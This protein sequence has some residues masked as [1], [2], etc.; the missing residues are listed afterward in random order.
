MNPI[1]KI[2]NWITGKVDVPPY[3]SQFGIITL[4]GEAISR[5][6]TD[7]QNKIIIHY[8]FDKFGNLINRVFPYSKERVFAME[9]IRKI[10]IIDR[11][12]SGFKFPIYARLN[13]QEASYTSNG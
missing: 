5:G 4:S 9:T 10:P 3:P 11:T 2:W 7:D 8:F 6:V 13:P 12:E 1:I